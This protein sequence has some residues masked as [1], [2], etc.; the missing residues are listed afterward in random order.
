MLQSAVAAVPDT[1]EQLKMKLKRTWAAIAEKEQTGHIDADIERAQTVMSY[2][3]QGMSQA[4]IAET[5]ERTQQRIDQI[6]R[7]GRFLASL[8][9]HVV[10]I[11]E[12]QFRLYWQD[13]A[14]HASLRALRGKKKEEA[15]LQY[16]QQIFQRIA[17]KVQE[18][19]KPEKSEKPHKTQKKTLKNITPKEV[20]ALHDAV[21][22]FQVLK[23]KE[24]QDAYNMI[25]EDVR[26][27]V[28]LSH[29][30]RSTYSPGQMASHATRLK[31]G[32]AALQRALKNKVDEWLQEVVEP[33][34][35]PPYSTADAARQ[36][37]Q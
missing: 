8:T 6:H 32:Y 24:V 30:D 29:G 10:K 2:I 35:N 22:D 5:V 31:K 23:R 36:Q 11:S 4:V 17:E 12:M 34:P 21:K 18:G 33:E 26:A 9:T 14:D 28:A 20:K 1:M 19:E 27:L 16:E 37:R 13:I 7:H 15:R 3:A 25:D